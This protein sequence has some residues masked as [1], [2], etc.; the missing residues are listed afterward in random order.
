MGTSNKELREPAEARRTLTK[1]MTII[2]IAV[3][4][5]GL[6]YIFKAGTQDLSLP[7]YPAILILTSVI[8]IIGLGIYQKLSSSVEQR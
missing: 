6:V 8:V 1:I 2:A 3:S 4:V 5:E 7:I